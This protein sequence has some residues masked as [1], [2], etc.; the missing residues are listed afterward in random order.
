MEFQERTFS[1]G[2]AALRAVLHVLGKSAQEKTIRK[3]ARTTPRDGTDEAGIISAAKRY[4]CSASEFQTTSQIS[5][6][7]WLISG[8]ARSRPCL[9]CVD[10]WQHWTAVVGSLGQRALMFDPFKYPGKR[11]RYSG[12]VPHSRQELIARWGCPDD[13]KVYYYG[14]RVYL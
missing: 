1:C 5:A 4:G 12:L 9:L 14:I 3:Y 8:L 6:W 13:G 7:G 10:N 2:P 11:K